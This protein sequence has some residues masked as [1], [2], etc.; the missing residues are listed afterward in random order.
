MNTQQQREKLRWKLKPFPEL[1]RLAWPIGV[2][3]LSYSLMTL[4]DTLFVGRLGAAALAGVSIGGVMFFT[5]LCFGFGLL[6]SVKV[7]VSQALGAG[8]RERLAGYVGAGLLTALALGAVHIV[9][10]FV[11]APHIERVTATVQSAVYAR[12][13]VE[14][15]SLCAP[16]ALCA[17][18]LREARYG[19]SDSRLPMR[20]ALAANAINIGLDYLLIVE[21]GFGVAGAAWASV[22][23][24]CVEPL[25]L[26]VGQRRDGFGLGR[27]ALGE[28]AS[29]W[30]IGVPLGAQMMLEVGAFAL[31]TALFASMSE[32][33]I[34]AHQIALQV[35]HLSFLPALAIGEAASVL[36]GQ[37]VGAD[38]DWLVPKLAHLTLRLAAAYTGLC[39]LVFA[40]GG[41]WI[42][43]AFTTQPDLI[44]TT[45][46]V[47]F[48]AGL[49][50][51]ADGAN[52]VAR[53]VLRGTGDVRYPA[54][55]AVTCAWLLAPPL[56]LLLGYTF[57]LGVVGGWWGLFV[58]L[59]I[60]AA[61]L[62]W[63]LSRGGWRAAAAQSRADQDQQVPSQ[64]TGA[65]AAAAE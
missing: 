42:A 12:S 59:V 36:V 38:E 21:L 65:V 32:V 64:P 11:L 18:T 2:S 19:L 31:L 39:G 61:V 25:W 47:L 8:R 55:V 5:L 6:R 30:R 15:R 58:E 14:I 29:V 57:G 63:R 54:V 50:Q 10:A 45:G 35:A 40:L 62:W 46:R 7:L 41:E 33:D 53:C 49:F 9:L 26:A 13:Y 16:L 44:L 3:M 20:A 23:A 37:A 17:V 51:L 1:V 56:A 48:V 34:A 43:S 52:I 27:R 4:V 24:Q 60:G 28:L 22:A